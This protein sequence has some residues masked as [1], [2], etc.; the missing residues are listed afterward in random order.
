MNIDG[1]SLTIKGYRQGEDGA[2]KDTFTNVNAKYVCLENNGQL[3]VGHNV[4]LEIKGLYIENYS[5][6]HVQQGALTVTDGGK[7]AITGDGYHGDEEDDYVGLDNYSA[8]KDGNLTV[9]KFPGIIKAANN[10]E[11]VI[12]HKNAILY[13]PFKHKDEDGTQ[14]S[15][16]PDQAFDID[17]SSILR[18]PI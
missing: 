16:L 5:D 4:S 11:I 2:T 3:T 10:S 13:D 14:I 15:Y 8:D 6:K 7:L 12:S 9:N 1:A 18:S 17:N